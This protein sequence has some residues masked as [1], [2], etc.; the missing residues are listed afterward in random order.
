MNEPREFIIIDDDA[1][2]NK[3]CRKIVEKIYPHA[4][5]ADFTSPQ[6]GFDHVV[7]TYANTTVE[8]K[9]ILL[10]DIMMPIMNAWDFLELYEQLDEKIKNQIS[11]YILSSSVN[12]DD[13]AKAQ[14]NK[15][16]EYYLIKPLTK[17]SIKLIVHVQNKR[18][19]AQA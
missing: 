4:A 1:I 17:E 14:T 11:I 10:L 8:S 12:K 5:I 7:K 18:M 6:D 9:V 3:L 15:N 13:M 19:N 2:N 16:V